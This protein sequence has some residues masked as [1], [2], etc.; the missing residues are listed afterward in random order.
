VSDERAREVLHQVFLAT[1]WTRS[2]RTRSGAHSVAGEQQRIGFARIL[3]NRPSVAFLDESTSSVDEGLEFAL[4]NTYQ[5][6]TSR[7]HAVQRGSPQHTQQ[8]AFTPFRATP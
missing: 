3:I 7:M 1:W 5:R 4:Y 2:T 8:T 6:T